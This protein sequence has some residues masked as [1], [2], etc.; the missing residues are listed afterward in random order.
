MF[1]VLRNILVGSRLSC[2]QYCRKFDVKVPFPDGIRLRSSNL[3]IYTGYHSKPDVGMYLN[4]REHCNA[5]RCIY[6][7]VI[8]VCL[9]RH[10][11]VG[12]ITSMLIN[13]C[14]D[15][16]MSINYQRFGMHHYSKYKEI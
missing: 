12:F 1:R 6:L 10:V 4:L 5:K 14:L 16:N 2:I 11:A 8:K 7:N 13:T 9:F 15:S 3:L